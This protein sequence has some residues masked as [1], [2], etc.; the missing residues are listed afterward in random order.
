MLLGPMLALIHGPELTHSAFR[1]AALG[2][3]AV[4]QM[5]RS[6]MLIPAPDLSS[7]ILPSGLRP[8]ARHAIRQMVRSGILTITIAHAHSGFTRCFPALSCPVLDFSA[9]NH[10]ILPFGLRPWKR[11]VI[12]QMARSAMFIRGPELTHSAFRPSA[13]GETSG[14]ADG[15]LGLAYAHSRA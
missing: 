10:L 6:A 2:E 14:K 9:R 12:R 11:Q 1:P 3:H 4:R 15:S 5:V 8:W 13:L 7:L